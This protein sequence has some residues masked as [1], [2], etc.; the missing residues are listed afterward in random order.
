MPKRSKRPKV[1]VQTFGNSGENIDLR[2]PQPSQQ[3]VAS[4][5]R[6]SRGPAG[7]IGRETTHF[8]AISSAPQVQ[9]IQPLFNLKDDLDGSCTSDSFIQ[10]EDESQQAVDFND[11][12]VDA[13][14][15]F[16]CVSS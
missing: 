7:R 6:V 5:N 12:H 9:P 11:D 1:V 16:V 14:S 13:G 4:I 2:S 3:A 15:N 8:V 10:V